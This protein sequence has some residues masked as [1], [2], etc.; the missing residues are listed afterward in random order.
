MKTERSD[1][2]STAAAQKKEGSE[3]AESKK[4]DDPDAF[5]KLMRRKKEGDNPKARTKGQPDT[6]TRADVKDEESWRGRIVDG[7][8]QVDKR[9]KRR[10]SL[11]KERSE[12]RR[13]DNTTQRER[14]RDDATT[15]KVRERRTT[16]RVE[17]NIKRDEAKTVNPRREPKG[18]STRDATAGKAADTPLDAPTDAKGDAKQL[19]GQPISGV[20]ASA[21][22]ATA[23]SEETRG[24]QA[25]VAEIANRIVESAQSGFDADGRKFLSMTMD[26]PGRGRL[27]IKLRKHGSKMQVELAAESPAFG[28]MLRRSRKDIKQHT[29][30]RGVQLS[31]VRVTR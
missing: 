7:E 11:D 6:K 8:A 28:R 17:R 18:E 10:G 16:E 15:K 12:T 24:R 19:A 22:K 29:R 23:A 25:E 30:E 4:P 21:A 26:I 5:D 3:R 20:E 31:S 1:S 14:Q 27:E 13:R 9:E 2:K